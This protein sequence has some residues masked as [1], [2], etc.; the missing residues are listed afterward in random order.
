MFLPVKENAS[1]HDLD[2]LCAIMKTIIAKYL[3]QTDDA[4]L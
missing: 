2:S 4:K 1:A 3:P